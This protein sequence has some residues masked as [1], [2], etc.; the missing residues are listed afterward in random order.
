M[1]RPRLIYLIFCCIAFT[2][3]GFA[4][5]F[6]VTNTNNSGPGSLRDAI[7]QADRNGT[8]VT[9]YINFNIPANRGPAVIRI[10]F[11]QLLPALSSNLV[12]DGTTQP[13]APLGN[14]SAKLTISLE[15]NTSATDYL[16]IFELNGLN[17]V[18]IYGLFLQALVFDRTSFIPPPN[19]FGILIRG[20]S[21]ISIG[22]LDKG[23]VISGWAR[24]IYAENTPQAGAI[25]GLTVQG[26]IMGLAPDGITNSLGSAGGRGPAATIPAT[27]Q[28]GV[29]VGLGKEIMIGGNQQALGNIIHSRVIDI[30]CQGLWWFGAD[31]KTTISYNRI[32]MDRN[33][34]YIN[35]DAGT[36][37][38]L[39]RFFRWIPRTNRFNPGIVIDHNSIGSRSR[40]NGIVMDSIM[41]YFLIENNTIGAEVNDGP[42]PGGYYGKGIHLFECDMGMIGGENFGKENIIRYWKQGAL[43]CDRTTNITFRYNST[44]CN[45]DRA[46][47]LNQWKEYNP[48]PFRIKPYV[49]INYLNLRDFVMEGTA[50]PNSW[51]DLYFDDNC[52]DCEGKQH[53]AGMFAVI[54]VGPTG[55]WNYSDIP[56][57]RGNFVVTAT[58]DYGATSEYSA[59]EIDT[60]ELIST[61][62][63]CKTQGGS[64]CGLKIVSGTEWEWL[65][66]A[67]TSVG[68]DTCLSNVAP[69][70]YLFKLRIG[71]GYCEK[72]YDFTIKDSVLDID[73]S[74]GVTV[75]N[76]RCGKSNGAIRGF[77]PKNASRWQ[78][79][80]G[81]GSIVSN[82]IDLTNVPAG[83][84]RFR[85]FNRLCDTVT[86]YYE[87]GD[88]TPGID[89]Q[90]IQVTATTCSKNNGSIT[91]IRISQTN[92]STV[93]WKDENGNIAG[94]GADLLNAAPGRYKLVVLDSAEA[95]GDS[96]AFY[97]IAATPAP[98]IDT[99]S[100]SINHAS[101]DQPNGSINGIRLLNT[102]APVYMVWV[103]EQNAVMGNTLNLSNLR[104][105]NYRLKIK[106][107]GTCDT[108]LSPVFEVRNNG[109]I[110]IDSTLLKINA[111]GCTRIS[112]SVTGI[113]INGADSWQW[114]NTSNN[115]V[116][117]NTTDL[118][119]VGA[120]NYQ[121]RVSNSVYGCSANSS[122]YTITV[123]NPIPLSVAR[124]GYKDAS[125]NNNNGS[126]S[127]SQFNGNSN[128]FS[129]VWLRDSSVNMGS[130]LTL[131]NLAPATYYL[132]ATDTNGC[133]QAVY[134]Q[135]VSMQ[136]LPQLNE[137]NV[138]LSNDTCSFKTGSI[139]GINAS[140]DVGNIT[141]RW[142]NNNVQ[143]G[144]G[145][146][147]TGL[148]PGN[149]YLLV[150]DINGCELRSRDYTVSPITTSLPAPRYRDQTI[151][152]YSSTTLKV[153]NPI[154]GASYELI[155][156]QTGQLIQKNTTGN[157]ELTAV[158]EDRML[159]VM[160][161][162]GA[163]SSPVAQVFI[164]VIDITKL[165]IPNAFTPNGDG[166]NDVFRIRV[167]GYFLMDELKIF[168]R[169]GQ[170]VFETKQVNK[171][172]DGTLRGKPLPVGTYYWVVEGLDV[173]GEKLRRA[174]SV[175]LLR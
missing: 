103:N 84:Y 171:D 116:V 131:Q 144:T 42:P 92:F 122:V 129:F 113:R 80:D 168:N 87:I 155:D 35:T 61:A 76:T 105:G 110:T 22:A 52:P 88:L 132:L 111:T 160:L 101:C 97:T 3:A 139:T 38:Q 100:M 15:G 60:T 163:C 107:A 169:W 135:L 8:S 134:K 63:L 9:D 143:A 159:Q 150:S 64:V 146:E 174:G 30:Y 32:G 47:E 118:L 86:S 53:V 140:S 25:T 14:S 21:D 20:G 126:I 99:I 12:I 119:S 172:W 136:P 54:R 16:Q 121:L 98:T 145:R 10:Q 133:A 130:D 95:C 69:G 154:N 102:L 138:R 11:N 29:Y 137:N 162:A 1:S 147:L 94:T 109:A 18:S 151:P 66:S 104:A 115:T 2:Q 149:Y 5:T 161:R 157:F 120:G 167:T 62:A 7:E 55:K 26:N 33:G 46:I 24:A 36:A 49:T 170:L 19:T 17:N 59:P 70:R 165:E 96:T 90:N 13:G 83:R 125:C 148:G 166:I 43:V 106:D 58:D 173:H 127:V 79:E 164:K 51:V 37:I 78:W 34:N 156:P 56:F 28:Y 124:A 81:N 142:Y 48:T 128:L 72:I 41:S 27:N 68:T 65:D 93:R 114:I 123:A 57:G 117:G 77:A 44:Y 158:N 23:N 108:V 82:D 74:A 85:V 67:G 73:S 112:G 175:T 71:P 45:K 31:S 152:R 4:D 89:A 153:E 39:H 50:P 75:L 91:G 40:L 6:L 141:Y